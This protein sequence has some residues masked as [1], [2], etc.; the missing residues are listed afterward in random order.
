M[1]EP[2]N[3]FYNDTN[4]IFLETWRLLSQGVVDRKS[5]FHHLTVA[6]IG[7]GGQPRLR[8]VILRGC[9]PQSWALRF[10]TDIRS[11]KIAELR[12]DLRVSLQFYDP[13][14]RI[15]IRLEGKASIHGDD[16]IADAAWAGSRIFSRQCYGI[17]PSPGT[18]IPEAGDYYWP[19]QTNEATIGGRDNFCA[20]SVE[21]SSFEWLYLAST[22]HRRASFTKTADG[23]Q[24]KWLAP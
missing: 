12:N 13:Q 24:A 20:V 11:T 14:M 21:A 4:E 6:S 2:K 16:A 18:T 8:T 15:Q 1:I 5:G 17:M 23:F 3:S 22:G 7:K 9:E 10:H 19:Q